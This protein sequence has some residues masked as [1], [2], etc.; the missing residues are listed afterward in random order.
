[1]IIDT[2]LHPSVA[3][4]GG[5]GRREHQLDAAYVGERFFAVA[6]GFGEPS[7]VAQ[8]VVDAVAAVDGLS[9]TIDAV[10]VVDESLTHAAAVVADR[11]GSGCTLTSLLLGASQAVVAHIGDSRLYLVRDGRLQRLT[12]DH[13]VVQSLVDEGRLTP[14]EARAHDDRVVLNRAI[15]AE[16]AAAP[17]LSLIATTPGDR[18]ILTTDGV[19][20]E[21][22]GAALADLL[23]ASGTV[24]DV[25]SDV[26]AAVLDAGADDNYH[27]V[28]VDLP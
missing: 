19:H 10:A 14:E 15:A 1:M 7:G 6:D 9:G 16:S 28:V 21:L 20:G 8:D 13:T 24:D 12:R 11:A 3:S 26:E 22:S 2:E 27:V 18:F 25:A 17:D 23:T 5:I 4:R